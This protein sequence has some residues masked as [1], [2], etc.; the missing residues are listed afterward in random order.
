MK[1]YWFFV[2]CIA[3]IMIVGCR[4]SFYKPAGSYTITETYHTPD[5][6]KPVTIIL[7]TRDCGGW[8]PNVAYGWEL[9][10][11]KTITKR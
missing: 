5:G 6:G 3:L 10:D 9:C 4:N 8:D 11:P 2:C 1:L 7:D